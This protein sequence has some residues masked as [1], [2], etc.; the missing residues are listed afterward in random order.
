MR[1]YRSC[2]AALV[3]ASLFGAAHSHAQPITTALTYQGRLLD[4]GQPLDGLVDLEFRLFDAASGGTQLGATLVASN[5]DVDQGLFTVQLD[6]GPQFDGNQRWIAV[7]VR[8]PPGVG[9]FTPLSG[10]QAIRATPYAL[11]ALNPGPQGP[12]GPQ[13]PQGPA[14]PPGTTQWSGL[15]GIPAGF[16][17]GVDNDTQYQAG[18]G[19]NLSGTLFSLGPHIHSASDITSGVLP[20]SFGGTGATSAENARIVLGVPGLNSQNLFGRGQSVLLQINEVGLSIRG[21]IGQS[22]DLTQWLDASGNVVARVTSTGQVLGSGGGG[23]GGQRTINIP[24]RSF[25][26]HNSSTQWFTVNGFQFVQGSTGVQEAVHE[27]DLPVGTVVNSVTF[28][29]F[30][31]SGATM[32][33]SLASQGLSGAGITNVASASS[34]NNANVVQLTLTPNHTVAADTGYFVR[35]FWDTSGVLVNTM[36]LFGAKVTYTLP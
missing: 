25:R 23:G 24:Y 4:A 12:E 36:A 13:G 6:F 19:L 2:R 5:V 20:T 29:V 16:A 34:V 18:A 21:A 15:S 31:G 27:L 35:A 33:V 9:L 1:F 22:A 3:A 8:K 28:F 30:D 26:A 14:G 7:A 10:R 32:T 17:D 11:F